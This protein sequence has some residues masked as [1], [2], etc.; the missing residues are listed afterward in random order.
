MTRRK[1]QEAR[2]EAWNWVHQT[3]D[4]PVH[5]EVSHLP[6]GGW[7]ARFWGKQLEGYGTCKT[8]LQARKLLRGCFAQMYPKHRCT[9]ECGPGPVPK[10]LR[11]KNS[12]ASRKL[13]S[14]KRGTA[15]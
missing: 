4:G 5:F 14:G 6:E 9:A 15:G 8:A 3:E 2:K 11:G 7:K 10:T 12:T 13:P 1:P